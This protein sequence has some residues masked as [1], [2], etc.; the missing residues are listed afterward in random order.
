MNYVIYLVLIHQLIVTL[1]GMPRVGPHYR[2]GVSIRETVREVAVFPAFSVAYPGQC[3]GSDE[4]PLSKSVSTSV[5]LSDKM[6]INSLQGSLM[7]E[8]EINDRRA[9]AS[10][11]PAKLSFRKYKTNGDMKMKATRLAPRRPLQLLLSCLT[12][13]FLAFRVMDL[14][15]M[16]DAARTPNDD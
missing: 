15:A 8:S 13:V 4:L 12:A 3:W 5:Q 9:T 1:A 10:R 6:Q 2:P 7:I 16:A 14:R 11:R